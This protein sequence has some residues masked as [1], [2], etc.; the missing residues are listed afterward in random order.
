MNMN[1]ISGANQYLNTP[2]AVAP[3]GETLLKEQ[4]IEASR[5]DLD[6][7]STILAQQAFQVNITEE[8]QK[9]ASDKNNRE[10]PAA[11]NSLPS[12][13]NNEEARQ[14]VNIIA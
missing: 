6:Q 11:G 2:K 9:L 13:N 5:S 7:K 12:Q 3:P 14:I 8:A 1:S 4:N 10:M